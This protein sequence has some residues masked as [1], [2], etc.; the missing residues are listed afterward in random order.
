MTPKPGWKKSINV[1]AAFGAEPIEA[2]LERTRAAGCDEV[3]LNIGANAALA[4]DIA[5]SDCVDLAK[6]AQSA[7]LAISALCLNDPRVSNLVSP[8]AQDRQSAVE[9]VTAA[10]E[11][12][13]WLGT[14]LL[15]L[16]PCKTGNPASSRSLQRAT[17]EASGAAPP[18]DE[19]CAFALDS[20]LSL[21][22]EAEARA[23]HLA[24]RT[25]SDGF[26]LSLGEMRELIDRLCS[27]WCRVSLDLATP[28]Q[29]RKAEHWIRGLGHRLV[30][31]HFGDSALRDPSTSA[32][33]VNW[34]GIRS[35]LNEVA[36]TGLLTY[37][38]RIDDVDEFK[39]RF[40]QITSD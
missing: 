6:Q 28:L 18:Y 21:R 39:S 36:Y 35:A 25:A 29:H 24:C 32:I 1:D 34:P 23:V 22:F 37:H 2:K 8:V 20:L 5:E 10:L 31:M 33:A 12:A 11:R 19:Q 17:V 26:R 30:C 15:V 16:G 27:P 7:G 38:D 40:D 9:L 3:E 14:D 13:A 4:T